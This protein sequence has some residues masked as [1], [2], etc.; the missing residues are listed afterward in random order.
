MNRSL[1]ISTQSA[2][3]FTETSTDE[4]YLTQRLQFLRDCGIE[5]MD[6]GIDQ[7]ITADVEKGEIDD[8]WNR[9]LDELYEHFTPLKNA[10]QKTGMIFS[11]MHAVFPLYIP[12]HAEA[13]EYLC[14]SVEKNIAI[15]AFLDCPAVVVHPYFCRDDKALEWEINLAMYRRFI[16]FAKQ[17]GVKIFLENMFFTIES[18][19]VEACCSSAEEACRYIDALNEEAGEDIF[20]FCFDTG[21]CTLIRRDPKAFIKT[22]GHRLLCLHLHDNNGDVDLHV[23]PFSQQRVTA[24]RTTKSTTDW[25][26]ICEALREI[27]YKGNLSFE[28][29]KS[30]EIFPE[31]THREL[32][33]LYSAIGR[34][35][36]NKILNG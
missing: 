28:A 1:L 33:K 6:F 24:A 4:A 8:F 34:H 30:F 12:G 29:Y 10:A 17:Y 35:F 19:P 23:M 31:A 3:L 32:L 21:H 11:Q 5:A 26:G 9:S 18:H 27:G 13:T 36:R 25:D 14:M 22:L 20:G 2:P 15:A 7:C 16:P